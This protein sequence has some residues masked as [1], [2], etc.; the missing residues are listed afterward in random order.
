MRRFIVG[1][2]N[3]FLF[4]SIQMVLRRDHQLLEKNVYLISV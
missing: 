4:C 2:C 3:K 1:D